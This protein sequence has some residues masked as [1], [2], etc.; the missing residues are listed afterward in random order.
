MVAQDCFWEGMAVI[1]APW[2]GGRRIAIWLAVGK[3]HETLSEK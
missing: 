3:K 1:P 2:E